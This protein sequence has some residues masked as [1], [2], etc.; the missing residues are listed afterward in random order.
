MSITTSDYEELIRNRIKVARE[1]KIGSKKR[2]PALS[3]VGGPGL[4]KSD[5]PR[6][7]AEDTKSHYVQLSSTTINTPGDLAGAIFVEGGKTK[8][9]HRNEFDK[10]L[11]MNNGEAGIVVLDDAKRLHPQIINE[12]MDFIL[13][14]KIGPD[15]Y[16][17][18]NVFIILT[19]NPDKVFYGN[20]FDPAQLGR[21]LEFDIT[22]DINHWLAWAS[23]HDIDDSIIS[24]IISS[25]PSQLYD[26]A[27]MSVN[28]R[29]WS[30][31]SDSMRID[32]HNE[33][34]MYKILQRKLPADS[35]FPDYWLTQRKGG[36]AEPINILTIRRMLDTG[37]INPLIQSIEES[38]RVGNIAEL[39]RVLLLSV[40]TYMKSKTKIDP[41]MIVRI[42][43]A[44]VISP[45]V[46]TV[47][48]RMLKNHDTWKEHI[49]KDHCVIEKT[50]AS[51]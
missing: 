34:L 4:G 18:E 39:H 20:K 5:I 44:D 13:L 50:K 17:P 47:Y 31:L 28:P 16:I 19:N 11:K 30:M 7:I 23:M 27:N 41:K 37:D 2:I 22:V 10:L 8:V 1:T 12:C 49:A 33:S 36:D 24:Y 26:E 29:M 48:L 14:G 6:C 46:F 15:L 42:I 40:A 43:T 32:G 25:G 38:V 35:P 3:V 51:I 9:A 21:L 45:D